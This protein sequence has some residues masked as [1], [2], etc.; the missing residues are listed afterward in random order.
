MRSLDLMLVVF[1]PIVVL[2]VS[3]LDSLPLEVIIY[4]EE[5]ITAM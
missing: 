4:P 1:N 3:M 2:K 5:I